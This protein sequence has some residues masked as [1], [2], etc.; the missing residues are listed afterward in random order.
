LWQSLALQKNQKIDW[1]ALQ[2]RSLLTQQVNPVYTELS[3]RLLQ[4]EM[5]VNT[6]VPRGTQ[7]SQELVRMSETIQEL[8]TTLNADK[9]AR[10]K[11]LQEREAGQAKLKTQRETELTVLTRERDL[12]KTVLTREREN[13]FDTLTRQQKQELDAIERERDSRLAQLDRQIARL[14]DLYGEL[15]KNYNQAT[16]AK[17]QQEVEDVRLGATAVPPDHPAPRGLATKSML[18]LIVGGI[19]GLFVAVIREVVAAAESET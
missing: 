3:S 1:K 8:D 15:A 6:L 17:A 19:M 5:E 18:A 12:K 7:L 16:M 2:G 10:E 13:Q 4:S 14:K 11:L 9:A